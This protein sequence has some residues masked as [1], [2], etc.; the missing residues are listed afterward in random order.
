MKYEEL[1]YP[2]RNFCIFASETFIDP[3]DNKR[4]YAL[5]S[6][7]AG[8]TGVVV[9]I[10]IESGEG[11]SIVLPSDEGAWALLCW[12]NERLLIGTCAKYGYLHCLDL[13]TRTWLPS[14]KD[15]NELYF[16]NLVEG[17]DGR[18]YGGTWPG[19]VL[20]RYDPTIHKLDNMGRM[21]PEE[22]NNYTRPLFNGAPGKI[23]LT[24]GYKD[25]HMVSWDISKE[26]Y[27]KFGRTGAMV[28]EVTPD[29]VCGIIDSKKEINFYNPYTLES[30]EDTICFDNI[31]HSKIKH[32]FI[33]KYLVTFNPSGGHGGPNIRKP[34]WEG[35]QIKCGTAGQSYFIEHPDGTKEYKRIPA[36][37]PPT[38]I[39]TLAYDGKGK[40]WGSSGL[41][42][43]IFHYETMTGQYYNTL[44]VANHGGEVYGICPVDDRIYMT[45]YCGGEHVVYYPD[46][47]W[48]KGE[49]PK[50]VK[51]LRPA[52]IRPHTRSIVGADGNVWTGWFADYGTYGGGISKIDV[53]T[54]EVTVFADLIQGQ[55]IESIAASKNNIFFA[56]TGAGNG[57]PNRRIPVWL[58]MIDYSGQI[59]WKKEYDEK[60][61]IGQMIVIDDYLF[62]RIGRELVVYDTKDMTINDRLTYPVSEKG[63]PLTTLLKYNEQTLVVFHCGEAL[64]IKIPEFKIIKK[65]ETYGNVRTAVVGDKN[66]IYFAKGSQLCRLSQ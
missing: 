45:S 25:T 55:A 31:D 56:T 29:F 64:F 49:N 37:A 6:F 58:V 21:S 66:Q 1:G 4:K 59:I 11:E 61:G 34:R 51:T 20:L 2:C 54:D 8:G 33:K 30:I 15:E 24:S 23:F 48:I 41:G 42:Q 63:A 57:L 43:T 62:V 44:E 27:V 3:K 32:N 65:V 16:W 5:S 12:N 35:G 19:G 22:G 36:E 46:K 18:I 52:F 50:T 28:K 17:S 14:L 26:E 13:K 9:L 7:V 60:Y 10:D 38:S 47:P 39:L 53:N 40:I